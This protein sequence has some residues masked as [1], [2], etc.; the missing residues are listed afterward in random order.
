M[1]SQSV[2]VHAV[3]REIPLAAFRNASPPVGVGDAAFPSVTDLARGHAP[4]VTF[5]IHTDLAAV[6]T[7]WRRFERTAEGTPFQSFEW[8][9]AWQ[10]HIG[11]LDDAALAIAVGRFA[12]GSTAFLCPFSVERQRTGRRLRWLGQDLCEYNAPLLAR[13]F[14]SRVTPERFLA[15]WTELLKRMQSD[16]RLR[17]DWIE[18]EKMPQ[19]VGAQVNP[20]VHLDV[21]PNANSAHITRLGDEWETFYRAKRSSATRR[22]DRAKRKHMSEFGDIRFM[23]DSEPG[24]IRQ[25]L[26]TLWEQKKRIFARKGIAD[27]F[28]RPGYREFFLDFASNPQSRHLAHIS[29]VEIGSTCAAANFAIVFGDCYYHVLS[30]YCD[31]QLTRYG[32]GTLHL[33]ELLAYAI[34]LGLRQ[35]DFTIGDEH[36][37]LE[38]CDVRLMLC[39][40]SAAA[41]WRGWPASAASQLRRRLKR[42]IKQTPL[43]WHLVSKLRSTYGALSQSRTP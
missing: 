35:F 40:Y 3:S 33:R 22:R 23:T 7:E 26:E 36:Y 30:S 32:P 38:W 15:V 14:S 2:R 13:D 5:R 42:L 17:H 43:A 27:I 29:R 37:K 25:T 10:R 1:A 8:L 16:P 31:G 41:T 12:D 20:F 9:S 6:E 4:D 28:A 11:V 19:T 24:D 18:L 39:D 34:K 21:T